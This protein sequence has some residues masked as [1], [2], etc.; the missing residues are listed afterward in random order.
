MFTLEQIRQAARGFIKGSACRRT[1]LAIDVG[2]V[3]AKATYHRRGH[4]LCQFAGP[5]V[6]NVDA[7][8][9]LAKLQLH[10]DTPSY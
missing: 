4:G 6:G 7:V 5:S 8:N 9:G 2:N 3:A 10:P 1:L